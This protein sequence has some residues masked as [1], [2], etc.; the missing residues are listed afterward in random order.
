MI[1]TSKLSPMMKRYM[2]IKAQSPDCLLFF[3]LGDF[4]EMFFEDAEKASRILDLVLTGRDCGL[5]RRAPMCGV[6]YHAVDN[7]IRRLIDAGCRVAICEQLTD[8]KESKGMVE[9]DVVRVVTPGTLVEEDI[10]D[11]KKSN[12]LASVYAAANGCGL[13]W[14]DI[15][16]GEFCLTEYTGE[17]RLEK[18]SDMLAAVEPSECVCN[19]KFLPL[20]SEVRYFRSRETKPRCYHDFAYYFT[21]AAKKLADAL[22]VASLDA[23]ECSNKEFAVSAAGGLYEYLLQTQKRS[24]RQLSGLVYVRDKSFMLLDEATRRNLELTARLRDGKRT[25]SLIGVLDRTLTAQGARLLMRWVSRPLRD[26]KQINARLGAVQKLVENRTARESLTAALKRVRDLERLLGRLAYGTAGAR[27]LI[28]VADTLDAVPDLKTALKGLKDPLLKAAGGDLDP[29]PEE[30]AVLDA[31]LERGRDPRIKNGGET[32]VVRRGYSDRLDALRDIESTAKV[33]L[34][35][36][37]ARERDE[38]GIRT[39]KVGFNKVFGYYIE[40]SKSFADKVPYRYQRKQTLVGGER[41]VTDELKEIETKILT[42][43]EEAAALE[44][45]ILAEL[46]EMLIAKLGALQTTARATAA[47]DALLSFATVSAAN[48]YV[49]PVIGS[50]VK[51]LKIKAGRHPV[52][53][54]LMERGAYVPND[55]LLDGEDNRT[56]VLTGPNMAGKST[57]MRQVALIV[58]MAHIGCFVPAESAEITLTDRIFTRIGASDDLGGG[59]STFMVEM[60]EVATIL[61][62]ATSSSLLILDEIGRGTSTYD[63]LAIAWAVLEHITSEIRAKTLFATHFHELTEAESFGGVKNY[64]VLV[65]EDRDRIVFLH[66]IVRGSAPRSF[67]V[68]VAS[69]AGVRRDVVEKAKRILAELEKQGE[70]RDANGILLAADTKR[71]TEQLGLF[72]REESAVEKELRDIDPDNLTPM[73]ALAV[74]ADLKRRLDEECGG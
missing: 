43:G 11:E 71:K 19:E 34:S 73:Q 27:E 59:Q 51:A 28:S 15:S 20:V 47:L 7:Y 61:N 48:G 30:A 68:E 8:P 65:G 6:P 21:G 56:V 5:E 63:G 58:L 44:S 50:K 13:A 40:V 2:E 24:L 18:L 49:R 74:L 52:V 62:Y 54:T 31:A 1:D 26:E 23:F 9:R 14:A 37:E 35:D 3:R 66:K 16:T 29:M 39:L 10:L 17:D 46:K 38:T 32:G 53:E 12:Y 57:Y 70:L 33:W 36:L 22:G 45:K 55:T 69:L 60:I 67:G 25:G 4:Y 64:R 41:F 42:A 72:D